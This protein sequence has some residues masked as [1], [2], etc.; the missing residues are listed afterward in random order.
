[1]A[2]IAAE[3]HIAL[4]APSSAPIFSDRPNHRPASSATPITITTDE[5]TK[6]QVFNPSAENTCIFNPNPIRT[7]AISKTFVS[8]NFNPG[9]ALPTLIPE[10]PKMIPSISA[11]V[12]EAR[13][14]PKPAKKIDPTAN[15]PAS[16]RPG[17]LVNMDFR[18]VINGLGLF[19]PPAC[20][21]DLFGMA[22]VLTTTLLLVSEN[23]LTP[24]GVV[25]FI[26]F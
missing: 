9:A 15:A 23:G 16:K 18:F 1:M 25:S 8:V 19:E 22:C 24:T 14:L 3:P 2:P 11:I 13:K 4:P 21:I 20:E 17:T 26:A 7:I 6:T 5:P 12:A 10:F